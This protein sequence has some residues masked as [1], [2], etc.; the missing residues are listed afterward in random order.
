MNL[1]EPEGCFLNGVKAV[2]KK[3]SRTLMKW[4]FIAH[5]RG[6]AARYG[7]DPTCVF[8]RNHPGS[9]HIG[10]LSR[11][12]T[13][14]WDSSEISSLIHLNAKLSGS[15][16]DGPHEVTQGRNVTRQNNKADRAMGAKPYW[17]VTPNKTPSLPVC[18]CLI[19]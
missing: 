7:L 11:S 16:S 18:I 4:C 5:V 9:P 8:R 15:V 3:Q 14:H 1:L 10:N 17:K 19:Q 2:K 13:S 12:L 6:A